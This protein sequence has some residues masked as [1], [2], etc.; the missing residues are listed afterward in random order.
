MGHR[1]SRPAVATAE[2]P[3]PTSESVTGNLEGALLNSA[4][5]T[6]QQ[7]SLLPLFSFPHSYIGLIGLGDNIA[8]RFK[9]A[10]L[11]GRHGQELIL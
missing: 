8:G 10:G 2:S 3:R 4:K 1:C 5:G 11:Y 9:L 6:L 7:A